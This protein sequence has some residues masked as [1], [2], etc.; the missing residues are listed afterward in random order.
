M[1]EWGLQHLIVRLIRWKM[2]FLLKIK[3]SCTIGS[4]PAMIAKGGGILECFFTAL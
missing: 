4:K 3:G 1:W 2:S